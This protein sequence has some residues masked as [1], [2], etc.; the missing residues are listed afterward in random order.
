MTIH[1]PDTFYPKHQRG[2]M[3]GLIFTP[4]AYESRVPDG[5]QIVT[6]WEEYRDVTCETCAL[7]ASA[8]KHM[9]SVPHPAPVSMRV[10]ELARE[11]GRPK[12]APVIDMLLAIGHTVKTP[13][14]KVDLLGFEHEALVAALQ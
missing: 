6:D 14:S 13:A 10:H 7:M 11:A 5:D 8:Y 1:L 2:T 3:C 9:Q 4:S 12:S